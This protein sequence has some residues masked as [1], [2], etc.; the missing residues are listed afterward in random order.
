[1][2]VVTFDPAA[3]Q[4]AFPEFASTSAATLTQYFN[5]AA[6]LYLNNTDGSPIQ[7][8]TQRGFLF[9]YLVAHLAAL[10]D[11]N[12]VLVGRLT[13][14]SEGSVSVA[15]DMGAVPGKAAWFMQTKYGAAYWQAT[16][17]Y[18]TFHYLRCG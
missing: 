11:P 16:A 1:M 12:R 4:S 8:A 18:R 3:F 15:A 2:A 6:A 13:Q 10:R 17:Q 9:N 5:E 14:A 7:D